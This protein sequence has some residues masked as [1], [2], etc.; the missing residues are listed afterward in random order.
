MT[1]SEEGDLSS[2]IVASMP[3]GVDAGRIKFMCAPPNPRNHP[4]PPAFNNPTSAGCAARRLSRLRA[5]FRRQ[6]DACNLPE[7]GKSGFGPFDAI[8]ASNLLCRRVPRRPPPARPLSAAAHRPR[9]L[10][11]PFTT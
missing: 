7:A 10:Q 8:L 4:I 1:V 6:G 5:A 11:T 9:Q 2:F 3:E